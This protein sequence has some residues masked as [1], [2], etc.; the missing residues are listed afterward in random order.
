MLSC[1]EYR[2]PSFGAKLGTTI[3]RRFHE[4]LGTA[5]EQEKYTVISATKSRVYSLVFKRSES[6]WYNKFVIMSDVGNCWLARG[7]DPTLLAVPRYSWSPSR[8]LRLWRWDSHVAPSCPR[9]SLISLLVV[10]PEISFYPVWLV[11]IK[12]YDVDT[13]SLGQ[14]DQHHNVVGNDENITF[15]S[16]HPP[17]NI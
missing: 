2:D 5:K 13:G 9:H 16:I 12:I 8:K 6:R 3:S 11:S 10:V 15:P 14:L 7:W 4:Q 17:E 1:W